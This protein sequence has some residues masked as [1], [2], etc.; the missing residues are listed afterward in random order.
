M[1]WPHRWF[2]LWKEEGLDNPRY[3]SI[4]DFI[5]P[6]LEPPPDQDRLIDYLQA[7][8]IVCVMSQMSSPDVITGE[9][10]DFQDSLSVRTDGVWLW[11]D[12]LPH[13]MRRHG[14]RLPDALVARIREMNYM[15]PELGDLEL[16]VILPTLDWPAGEPPPFLKQQ[17]ESG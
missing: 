13:Y 6:E 2:G 17:I 7:A 16:G 9:E 12:D 5:E 10:I 1:D 4:H 11:Y 15:P 14:V 3:P 8:P